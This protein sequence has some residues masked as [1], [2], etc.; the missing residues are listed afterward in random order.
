MT[1]SVVKVELIFSPGCGAIESTMTMVEEAVRELDLAAD[2]SEIIVDTEQKAREL[3]F[4]GSPSIRVNG[5]DV[6]PG[7]EE[8]QD[9]GLG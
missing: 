6:E 3:K 5:R 1:E 9:Y 2:V 7:A 4:L 8:R